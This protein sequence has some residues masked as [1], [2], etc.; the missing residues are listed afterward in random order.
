MATVLVLGGYGGFGARLSRR[1]AGD[2]WTV[3]VGGRNL[4]KAQRFAADVPGARGV[5][6]DRTADCAGVL[7]ELRPALVIDAAGPFQ[8]SGYG[9]VEA[10]IANGIAYLDLA[11]DRAF[12]CGIVAFDK[13]ARAVGAPIISGASSVPALSGAV[14]RELSRDMERI[15]R[16]DMAL[17]AAT[18]ASTGASI[19]TAA[20]SYPGKPVRLWRGGE[21]GT[22]PGWSELARRRYRVPGAKPLSRTVGLADVPD[23][24]LFPE[25]FPGRPATAFYAG[26]EWTM[27]AVALWLLGWLV[28][29]GWMQSLIPLAR[30][31]AP[32]Q[33]LFARFGGQRSAMD[34]TV[35]GVVQGQGIERRWTIVAER[36]E[37]PEIP[38]LAA[39][40]LA[41]RLA[42]GELAPGARPAHAELALDDFAPLFAGL[43]VRTAIAEAPCPPL[44]RRVMGE[45][46]GRLAPPVRAMHDLI[47][48][49]RA[50]GQGRVERG[51]SPIARLVGRIMGFPPTGDY[52]VT[53]RFAE[54]GGKERWSRRF[55]THA[56]ASEMSARGEHLVE[57]FG[58]LR[59]AFALDVE[60]DGSL[61]MRPCGWSVFGAPMPRF[62]GPQIAASERSEGE[63]FCFDVAVALPLIGSI[64]AYRGWLER[65]A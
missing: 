58:P 7:A 47:G 1:L 23:H 9:V 56:F 30:W 60:P 25:H 18:R 53:V 32:V 28:R 5:R 44:Y 62:L 22:V 39:Q 45:N 48:H 49:G 19:V 42:S 34:I 31:F 61:A 8:G 4:A 15:E 57:R 59:F 17:S 35:R 26:A 51:S 54:N 2:G 52:P 38:T 24:E 10:C 21:W 33:R 3:L 55:G 27:Q 37:G 11:D 50:E 36:G 29:W 20:L 46:F 12:V 43:A 40:L 41:R 65:T 16:I 64:V 6:I 63:R 13:A 14:V